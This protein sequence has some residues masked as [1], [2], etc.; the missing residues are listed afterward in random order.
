ME[1]K[2]TTHGND[3]VT[4]FRW[5]LQFSEDWNTPNCIGQVRTKKTARQK[6]RAIAVRTGRRVDVSNI[7]GEDLSLYLQFSALPDGTISNV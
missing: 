7:W 1:I 3:R 6:A 4:K 2:Y 5:V